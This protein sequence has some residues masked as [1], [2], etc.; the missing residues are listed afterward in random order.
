MTPAELKAR[1][2]AEIDRRAAEIVALSEDILRHPETGYRETRT[3][4]VVARKFAELGLAPRAGL[5]RTGVKARMRGRGPGPAVGI[6][7]ELDSLVIPDHPFADPE[8]GAAHACGHNSQ[9]AAMVGA[10]IGLRPVLGE[11]DGDVVLFAVPAEECIQTGWRLSLRDAGELHHTAGKAEL[12]RLGHFDDVDLAL[13]T[14]AGTPEPALGLGFTGTGS[15]LMRVRFHGRA[16]HAAASPEAGISAYKAA[17]VAI[18]AIDAHREMFREGDGIRVHHLITSAGSAVSSIPAL[19]EMEV[20]VRA[21]T[22][23]AMRDAAARVQG[24]VRGG[25]LAM[26]ADVEILTTV[27]FLPYADDAPLAEVVE[28]SARELVGD[29]YARLDGPGGGSTDMG[30]LGQVM[31]VVQAMAAAGVDAPFHSNAFYTAD[32]VASAVVPAKL[33][34]MSAIDLLHGG[35]ARARDVLARSGP[36]LSRAEFVRLHDSLTHEETFRSADHRL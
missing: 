1:A 27:S 26:G 20:L 35:A 13:L 19:T 32:H 9:V 6:L 21:R 3:A 14:H 17:T 24:A 25:A 4:E 11:L 29:G 15:L 8:T 36:K 22:I 18:S 16:A 30:D 34:A 7:G 5:A 23:E 2:C 10:G 33:M 12:I 28:S 31:P